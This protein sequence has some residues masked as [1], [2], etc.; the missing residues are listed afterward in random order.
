MKKARCFLLLFSLMISFSACSSKMDKADDIYSKIH[1]GYY[2]IDSYTAECVVTSFTSGG[3]N[4]YEMQISYNKPE[5]FHRVVSDEM[6]LEIYDDKTIVSK[7]DTVI[8]TDSKPS[9]MPIFLETFFKSYYESENTAM[10]VSATSKSN[11]I[12]LECEAVNSPEINGYMK[13][14]IDKKSVKPQKMQIYDDKDNMHTQ[15]EF[16]KFNF[17]K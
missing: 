4:S 6:T 10:T 13:L 11:S 14:W 15:I 3:E 12:V 1:D 8:E 17:E 5:K 2:D 9:D 16:E 7:G